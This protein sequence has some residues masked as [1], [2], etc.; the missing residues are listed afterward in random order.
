MQEPEGFDWEAPDAF[1]R[2]AE[3]KGLSKPDEITPEKY[4]FHFVIFQADRATAWFL[5]AAE[6]AN[7]WRA[8]AHR[9]S[10]ANALYRGVIDDKQEAKAEADSKAIQGFMGRMRKIAGDNAAIRNKAEVNPTR[11]RIIALADELLG[12]KCPE[13]EIVGRIMSI[14]ELEGRPP[15]LV[16]I[17]KHLKTHPTNDYW[18]KEK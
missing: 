7:A 11:L 1:E 15:S 12:N 9:K 16:T 14:L 2:W 13:R 18:R 10:L 4:A 17:R 5:K 6:A 3:D 8:I